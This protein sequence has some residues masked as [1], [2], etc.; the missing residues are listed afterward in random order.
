M[1]GSLIEGAHIGSL[2]S[3]RATGHLTGKLGALPVLV[4][5]DGGG[6]LAIE[7]RC[8]HLGFPL[9][10][11]TFADGMVTC[12]WHHARFDLASGCALDPWADDG[13]AFDVFIDGDEVWVLARSLTDVGA[14]WQQRL[15]DGL[16]R[17]LTL[18]IAKAVHA[19]CDLPDGFDRMLRVAYD[20]GDHNRA[21]GWGSGMTVLTCMANLVPHLDPTDR[22]LAMVHALVFLARDV[23][24]NPPRFA[25][26][27][28]DAAGQ[29]PERLM[30]W[31]RSFVET[32]STDGAERSLATAL[33]AGELDTVERAMFATLTDHVY[34][35]GGHSLDLTNKAFE[36]L[37]HVGPNGNGMLTSLVGQTCRAERSEETSEWN[38]PFD[39]VTL[40]T[41]TI[42]AFAGMS[43]D[44]GGIDVGALGW[45]LLADE[46]GEVAESLV[47]AGR[48]GATLEELARAVAFAAA[49]RLVRFH[50]NNDPGDWDT[51]HHTFTFANAV[52]QAIVRCPSPELL[53]GVVHGALRVQLDRFLN[54]PAA[55][56]PNSTQGT[57]DDLGECWNVQGAVDDAGRAVW[58]FLAAGGRGDAVIAALGRALLQEDAGFHW[59]QA[60]EAGTRQALAWP[61]GSPESALILVGVARFLAAHT[62]TRRELATISHTA[63]RLRRGDAMFEN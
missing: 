61:E 39:L 21:A 53:R 28:L 56:L 16:E 8:P 33:A 45:A 57:L 30:G 1:P 20:F 18:V 26:P 63:V 37:G 59:Y 41:S 23:G 15:R 35:D 12:H 44:T 47:A 9:H 4:V 11:G 24:G 48:L 60:I 50:L 62:P 51:V 25:Q 29:S 38:H 32:R 17:Q 36:A 6:A 3:L 22:P 10:R 40:A 55:R 2:A 52:H 31:Y 34:I 42:A 14:R 5:W 49:L 27:P 43:L 19:L 46:P 54:V 13:T 7:D 58:G